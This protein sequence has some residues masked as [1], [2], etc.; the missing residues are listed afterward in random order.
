LTDYTK[1]TNFTSKDTLSTGNPLKIIKGAEFDT[2]F[3]AIATAVA[4]KA[5][6]AGPTLTGTTTV[7][8]LSATTVS[9]SNLTVSGNA[10]IAAAVFEGS[11]A[12][13]YETT[14]NVV[15]PTADRT[16]LLP[17]K[18][19]TIA[20][21]SDVP[22]VSITSGTGTYAIS[23]STTLTVTLTAHNR[24]VGEIVYLNF[25]SGTAVSGEFTVASVTD[26][27]N[28]TVTYGSTLTTSG[29]VSLSYSSYGLTRIASVAQTVQGT[30]T[31]T[32]I[33]PST[34]RQ[35]K[36]VS[37]TAVAS[38]SGTSIDFTSIP[39][40]VKRIT[41]MFSGV[42]TSS[43]SP[44]QIQIGSG[45]VTN[46]GYACSNSVIANASA[47]SVL[48]TSGFGIGIN[49]G[50]WS[51]ASTISGVF[52]IDLIGSNIWCCSGSAGTTNAAAT[53]FTNGSI[54]LGGTLD[55]IRITT[56]NGTDTFD[57]GSINILYE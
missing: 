35:T 55:R 57:A 24:V 45:S 10:N 12:D 31:D 19:G 56:V 37:G 28:F 11:T 4:T 26:A 18:S 25:T 32:F 38:T 41:V 8:T 34:Y 21:T 15:D 39:S 50:N 40:W 53:F 47:I 43:T 42:S 3:N 1:S 52:V 6:A 48:F 27:N 23:G 16:I 33:S 44:P 36:L 30:S 49:T 9:T 13:D 46:T 7:E 20:L 14:L 2:E 17:N 54:T 5:N 29:N 51:G 22:N